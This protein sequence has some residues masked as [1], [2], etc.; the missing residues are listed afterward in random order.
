VLT[1]GTLL[2]LRAN[3]LAV[4]FPRRVFLA[5]VRSSLAWFVQNL[6]WKSVG[7]VFF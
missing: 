7:G 4:Q 6:S 3:A 5:L 1:L 2:F